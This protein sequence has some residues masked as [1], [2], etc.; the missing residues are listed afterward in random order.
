MRAF[1]APFAKSGGSPVLLMWCTSGEIFCYTC[2]Q[3]R[4]GDAPTLDEDGARSVTLWNGHSDEK[5]DLA[6]MVD[7]ITVDGVPDHVAHVSMGERVALVSSSLE[8]LWDMQVDPVGFLLSF[9]SGLWARRS[10]GC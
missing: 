3:D 4:A 9:S 8:K 6:C 5:E 10:A 2:D 7:G 1:S